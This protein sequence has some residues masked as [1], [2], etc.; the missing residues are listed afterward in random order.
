[1]KR[2]ARK[3]GSFLHRFA[4]WVHEWQAVIALVVQIGF[5][6]ALLTLV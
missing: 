4:K 2:S 5:D 1:M 6:V 3:V